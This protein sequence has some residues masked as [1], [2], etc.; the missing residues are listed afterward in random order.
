MEFDNI[1]SVY[2]YGSHVYGTANHGS[3]YDFIA[4]VK[5]KHDLRL[6]SEVIKIAKEN[7]GIEM[8]KSI[9]ADVN[10]Y[11]EEEF[12][13][14]L[15]DMEI[16]FLVCVN[17]WVHGH[18]IA[19]RTLVYGK[20]YEM[21]K[22]DLRKL[23]ESISKKASNSWVKSKK[24]LQPLSVDYAPKIGKKSAWHA[25]RILAFGSQLAKHRKINVECMNEIY[26]SIMACDSWQ[27]IDMQFRSV[28]N[29][30]STEFRKVAPK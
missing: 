29:H 28:Y 2:I 4:V 12:L 11:T 30:L 1:I 9:Q 3:D 20:N 21:P 13:T 7:L 5:D 24:K 27:E 14:A 8:K 15:N 18:S 19:N 17:L 6:N 23:R 10:A 22:L 25:L 26:D 16:S